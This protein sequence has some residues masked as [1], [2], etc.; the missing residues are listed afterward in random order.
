M[1]SNA[2]HSVFFRL[3]G[4][5]AGKYSLFCIHQIYFVMSDGNCWET[6]YYIADLE[7]SP[8]MSPIRVCTSVFK[9][10]WSQTPGWSGVWWGFLQIGQIRIDRGKWKMLTRNVWQHTLRFQFQAQI[11]YTIQIST[12]RLS[13]AM[14]AHVEIVVWI[15]GTIY[16]KWL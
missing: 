2:I 15:V 4:L 7:S 8:F 16:C 11:N 14:C 10:T 3:A 9:F 6:K 12:G 1:N 13:P 5:S